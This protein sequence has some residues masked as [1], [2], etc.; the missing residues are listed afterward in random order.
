M[1]KLLTIGHC[2]VC[3]AKVAGDVIYCAYHARLAKEL[4]GEP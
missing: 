4:K 3:R 1:S 2:V